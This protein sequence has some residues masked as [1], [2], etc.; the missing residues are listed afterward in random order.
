[1]PSSTDFDLAV[2]ARGSVGYDRRQG[3]GNRTHHQNISITSPK[4]LS[5]KKAAREFRNLSWKLALEY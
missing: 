3:T 1:M 4:A 5:E 2:N